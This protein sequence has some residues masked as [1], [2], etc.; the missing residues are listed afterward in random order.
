MLSRRN[1]ISCQ[2]NPEKGMDNR[3]MENY[4][5]EEAC[6]EQ[7]QAIAPDFSDEMLCQEMMRLGKDPSNMGRE[8]M[9]NAVLGLMRAK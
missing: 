8:Q 9:L 2:F 1:F 3:D 7:L 6:M 4:V 5:K